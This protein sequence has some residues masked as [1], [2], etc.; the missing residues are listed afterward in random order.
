MSKKD[1]YKKLRKAIG[2]LTE[3]IH[4][5]LELRREVFAHVKNK[6]ENFNKSVNVD[7]SPV[8]VDAQKL[9]EAITKFPPSPHDPAWQM[10]P[11][12][13][14][15]DDR[16]IAAPDDPSRRS[17]PRPTGGHVKGRGSV[18]TATEQLNFP[19]CNTGYKLSDFAGKADDDES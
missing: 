5:D 11:G 12:V 3:A 17:R 8:P 15:T 19:N 6:E 14:G 16:S 13:I 1:D 9:L 7:T 10:P 18:F 2:A 4:E